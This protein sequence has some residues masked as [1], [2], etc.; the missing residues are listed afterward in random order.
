MLFIIAS[1]TIFYL[2]LYTTDLGSLVATTLPLSRLGADL[3]DKE[4]FIQAV[5]DHEIDGP[6]DPIPIQQVCASK[7]WN[8][9]LTF[10]CG[11]P[12]GGIGNI[13]NV[14]LT[15]LRYAIEA[16]GQ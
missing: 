11:A 13:R 6:F 10:I 12:Q 4:T 3:D 16:G 2:A 14:F 7:K 1:S 15:C 8:D 9:D 5:L